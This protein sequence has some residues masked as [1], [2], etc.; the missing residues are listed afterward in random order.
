MTHPFLK[1]NPFMSL[2]LSGANA[3][4]GKVRARA[5]AQTGRQAAATVAAATQAMVDLWAGALQPARAK[6][7]VRRRR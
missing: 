7:Q 5:S 3:I 2:W 1:K 4:A 6:R